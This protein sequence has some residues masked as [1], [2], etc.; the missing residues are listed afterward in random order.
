MKFIDQAII[1]VIAGK[2]GD[3]G[4]SFLREKHRPDGG[5]DGGDGGNGGSIFLIADSGLNTLADFRFTRQY[6]ADNGQRGAGHDCF[7]KYGKDL[8]IRVPLGTMVCDADTSEVI[9]DVVNQGA[10]LLVAQGGYRGLGNARFKSSTN[11]APTKTTHGK[12]GDDR[13]L[14]LELKVLADVGLVGLP[15]AGKSTLLSVVSSARPKVADYPFTT[16]WPQLGVVDVGEASSFVLADIPG[17][18]KGAATGTGLGIDFLKHLSRTRIL[19]HLVDI[20]PLEQQDI[21]E[22]IREIETELAAFSKTLRQ[23]E[24]WLVLNKTDL[25]SAQDARQTVQR[26]KQQLDWQSPVFSISAATTSGCR[27]LMRALLQRLDIIDRQ[28]RDL[29]GAV[30]I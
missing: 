15:N 13:R 10:P 5:P 3:G 2:G 6:R 22:S 12:P 29:A 7:G 8:Y 9:G 11:Q 30:A 27:Q 17:L 23:R 16:L 25:M 18:I 24:R 14:Q 26:V 4:L 20:A 19:V 28:Q 1:R 21:V